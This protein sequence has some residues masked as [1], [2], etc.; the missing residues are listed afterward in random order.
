MKI[1]LIELLQTKTVIHPSSVTSVE[2]RGGNLRVFLSGYPWWRDTQKQVDLGYEFLFQGVKGDIVRIVAEFGP[3]GEAWDEALDD[4]FVQP[5]ANADWA[6]PQVCE[7]YCSEPLKDAL[8]LYV[9]LER[10]LQSVDSYFLP[11]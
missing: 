8:A 3:D 2:L 1:E 5:I 11:P 4:L 9:A 6:Q 7:L 10:H